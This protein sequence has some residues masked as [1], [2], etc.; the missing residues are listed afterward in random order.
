MRSG[1]TT[2]YDMEKMKLALVRETPGEFTVFG[3]EPLLVPLPDL[4]DLLRL[5][6]ERGGK[7]GIQTN[8]S[9]ITPA[10][11]TLFEKYKTH[12]GVSMDGPGELNDARWVG[13][14]E[15]TREAT[16]CSQM[17]LESLLMRGIPCSL[18]VTLTTVNA[19]PDR[20]D[21]LVAWL[22]GL[23]ERGLRSARLHVLEVDSLKAPR[24]SDDDTVIAL[25]RLHREEPFLKIQFDVFRE[26]LALLRGRD[27]NVTCIWNGCDP[28]TT[29]A[30]RGVGPQ[31]ES[32]N[33]GR[34]N[35]DDKNWL[36][37]SAPSQR[38]QLLLYGT[39]YADGGCEGC[40]FFVACKGQCP[41]EAIDGD[42]RNRSSN[43]RIWFRIFEVLEAHLVA[44]RDWP[45]SLRPDLR[46]IETAMLGEWTAN[47]QC[48]IR[49]GIELSVSPS[50]KRDITADGHGD[51]PHGDEHGDHTDYGRR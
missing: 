21:R 30:V 11:L 19:S 34:T 46:Q 20:L 44:T 32:L 47:R 48:S 35:K 10:H 7:S 29:P 50:Q 24:L 14:L 17:A 15:R 6:F 12:V 49:R 16:L 13:S 5:S 42:P 23:S 18:I 25:L 1:K 31:G 43:C 37:A 36:K 39:P 28:G 38:R 4:E 27:D 51:I 45:V 33:C 3:G 40:R 9:L 2:P 26:M 41:G 8:A 22:G